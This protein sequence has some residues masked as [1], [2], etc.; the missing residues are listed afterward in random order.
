MRGNSFSENHPL[1]SDYYNKAFDDRDY[2][3]EHAIL[4][5]EV[6]NAPNIGIILQSKDKVDF[7]KPVEGDKE[8]SEEE[9]YAEFI[10][11]GEDYIEALDECRKHCDAEEFNDIVSDIDTMRGEWSVEIN[12]KAKHSL[13]KRSSNEGD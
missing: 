13:N 2:F 6:R 5:N 4:T 3:V 7:W 11:I 10:R 12:Y 1:F 8:F 9:A